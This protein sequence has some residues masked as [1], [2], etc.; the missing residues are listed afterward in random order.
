MST[1]VSLTIL[2]PLTVDHNKIWKTLKKMGTQNHLTCLLRNPYAGQE[3]TVRTGHETTYWF[4]IGKGHPSTCNA[5]D[6]GFN[7]WVGKILWRRKWQPTPVIL[8]GKSHGYRILAGTVQFS[9]L[10][11]SDS[12]RPHE[13][14][15][16]RPP[17]PSPTPRVHPNP[18]PLSWWWH[19]TISSSVVPFSDLQSFPHS[20]LH[21]RW[22]KDWS[23]SFSVSPSNEHPGL[24]SFRMDWLDLLVVQGTLKSLLQHHS[25]KAS[26]LQRSAFFIVQL[27]HPYVTTGKA[28]ALT[29]WTLVDK[30]MSLLFNMLSR[31]I[32]C[33]YFLSKEYS[34]F[35]F[36]AAITMCS[37]FGAQK[38]K[39]NHCFHCFPIYL[40]WSDGPGCHD[41][42]FLNVELHG[43]TETQLS[44]F[45]FTFS[46]SET[47]FA[48]LDCSFSSHLEFIS[49]FV[50]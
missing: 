11:M 13:P 35:N 26:I 2:I 25:S 18:C 8:P 32:C 19:P 17:C 29:R 6:V 34:S 16:A 10:V 31:L 9:R 44:N 47:G 20:A 50:F 30:V 45:T 22:P 21:I 33:H 28:I 1:S 15:H 46:E 14:Q 37:D 49:F 39:V 4:Q 23:F 40:P 24:I 12:L 27:S 42:S 5:G 38:N 7:P 36:M 48:D 3:A 43:I 41:L